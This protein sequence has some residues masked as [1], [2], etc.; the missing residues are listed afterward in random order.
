MRFPFLI[1]PL[2]QWC[3][4]TRDPASDA[5]HGYAQH[6]LTYLPYTAWEGEGA[7]TLEQARAVCAKVYG[8][9]DACD[10]AYTYDRPETKDRP[11]H[12]PPPPGHGQQLHG[13]LRAGDDPRL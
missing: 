10:P 7:V 4:D 12:V 8:E 5:I 13:P 1:A 3:V 9:P 11:G 2:L 6:M